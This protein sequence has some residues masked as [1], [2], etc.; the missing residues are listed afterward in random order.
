MFY[1]D[2]M[3]NGVPVH[4]LI[5]TGATLVTLSGDD[6]ARARVTVS[7]DERPTRSVG[8]PISLGISES[9][10][11]ELAGQTLHNVPTAVQNGGD[12][13]LLGLNAL[14]RLGG[15]TVKTDRIIIQSELE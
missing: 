7:G 1:L 14:T 9:R 15:V 13:S 8:G 2:G 6:A 5:D 12:M 11:I 4:F 10:T 3:V